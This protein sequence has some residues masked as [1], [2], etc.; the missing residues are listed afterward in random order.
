VEVL[1]QEQ[2]ENMMLRR[3]LLKPETREA[4]EL[5]QRKRVFKTKC[6]I[7]DKCCHLVID[8]GSTENLVSTK[9]MGKLKLKRT[10]HPNMYQ[11]SWL[12]KGQEVTV[13]EQCLLSFQTGSF[14]EKVLCNMIEMDA[15]HV[16][17]WRL[18]MFDRKVFHGG[19]ENSY[20]FFKDGQRYKLVPM[21]EKNMDSN[22]SKGMD[23]SNNKVMN[24]NNNKK[25]HGNNS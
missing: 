20:E 16:F 11:V 14:S 24:D 9:V 13:T 5:E 15:C 19:R 2:G 25:L 18:W 21:L 7:H 4:M 1:Q 3:V 10:P 6:K 22:N 23:N 8:G 17:L 12:Q